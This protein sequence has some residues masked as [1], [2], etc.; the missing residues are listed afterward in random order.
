MPGPT[1]YFNYADLEK[2]PEDIAGLVTRRRDAMGAAYRLFYSDPLQIVRGSGTRLYDAVG[3]EYLDAY[4]NVPTAGHAHPRIIEAISRQVAQV[5]THTR[6]LHEGVI[7]YSEQL[8]STFADH[9]D[10][11]MYTCTGS[12]A[13]DLALRIAKYITSGTGVIV[14]T[15]AYHGITT[16]TA[17]ISPS[18]GGPASVPEWVEM[19]PAPD[20]YRG[21]GT[22]A[23]GV[24]QALRNFARRGIKPAAIIFDSIFAS[25]GSFTPGPEAVS[26]AVDAVRKAGGLAIADEVQSGFGRLG[27]GMWG[28]DTLGVTPDLVTIGKPMGSGQPIAGVVAPHQ[29]IDRFG[30][31]IRYFSTFAG[32][33]VS[34]AA[35]QATLDVLGDEELI[36]N[37]DT[38]GSYLMEGLRGLAD[39]FETIGDVRGSGLYLGVDLVTDRTTKAPAG[40]Y[41]F[42]IVNAMKEN[43]VLVAAVG[44]GRNVLKIRPPLSFNGA[45]A[46]MFLTALRRSLTSV[47]VPTPSG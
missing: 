34:V 45:D 15:E 43:H 33:P 13:N 27:Q 37:A 1:N 14:T 11:I 39:Q 25:D 40:D 36:K 28:Y 10:N 8:L 12:E 17:S 42:D 44:P 41:A 6:Y 30:A 20:T 5:N 47:P 18:L 46:E 31:D 32:N 23:A 2:L 16:E 4:N 22:F 9:L 21:T 24:E 19:V 3:A 35:A 38:T 26:Q 7:N 29:L